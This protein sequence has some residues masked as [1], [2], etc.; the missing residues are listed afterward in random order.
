MGE[1]KGRLR[2][3]INRKPGNKDLNCSWPCFKN[4]PKQQIPLK[5]YRDH[6]SRKGKVQ[7]EITLPFGSN[8]LKGEDPYK[9]QVMVTQKG[10]SFRSY[11]F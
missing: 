4:M 1:G 7:S 2:L 6:L 9:G 10:L 3:R 11:R 5:T 8:A